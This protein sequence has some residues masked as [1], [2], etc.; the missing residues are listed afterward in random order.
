MGGAVTSTIESYL[1]AVFE[2]QEIGERVTQARLARWFKVSP[3]ATAEVV[4]RME[5]MDLITF[6][7]DR[8]IVLSDEGNRR[9]AEEAIRHRTI[10]RY[11]VD[12]LGVPWHLSDEEVRN[13]EPG[14]SD[15]VFERMRAALGG[16]D[17]CP[18]GNPIPGTAAAARPIDDLVPLALCDVGTG[19]V[20]D[21]IL[22]DL[23]LDQSTLR[24]LEDNRLLPG[25][26]LEVRERAED[27][28]VTIVRDGAEVAVGA[29]LA[30]HVLCVPAS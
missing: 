15:V 25:A 9:A 28:G 20:I 8:T 24:F 2:L 7:D 14:V 19:V 18:H 16:V 21:R 29:L 30:S 27:G 5:K 23:E 6:A 17:R 11:L 10:E 26:T 12:V 3:P 1:E 4:K 13:M 22:E